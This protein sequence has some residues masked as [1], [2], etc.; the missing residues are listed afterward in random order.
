MTDQGLADGARAM[1]GRPPDPMGCELPLTTRASERTV[2][3]S[4]L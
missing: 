1:N 2:F 3:T 4:Q